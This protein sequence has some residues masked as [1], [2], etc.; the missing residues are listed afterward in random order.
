DALAGAEDLE[1]PDQP[2]EGPPVPRRLSGPAVDDEVFRPLRHLGIE[3]VHEHPE[4]GLLGPAPA[5]ALGAPRRADGTAWSH[6]RAPAGDARATG[7]AT[8][9]SALLAASS[10]AP[11]PSQPSDEGV[12]GDGGHRHH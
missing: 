5:G 4:S 3:V 2:V 6:G 11:P 12:D 8:A 7:G 9:P 1:A 10:P